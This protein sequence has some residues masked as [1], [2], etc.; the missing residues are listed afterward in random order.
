MAETAV[1]IVAPAGSTHCAG[2]KPP[3]RSSPLSSTLRQ[4]I[5]ERI[6]AGALPG[7]PAKTVWAGIGSGRACSGCGEPIRPSDT[8]IELE[9]A[10]SR[11]AIRLHR[12]CFTI[13][14]EECDHR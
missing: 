5:R 7:A 9:M 2:S 10:T 1:R 12:A 3:I 11:P 6:I 8:E 14:R 13:W 4:I